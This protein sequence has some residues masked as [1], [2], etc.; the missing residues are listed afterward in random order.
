LYGQINCNNSFTGEFKD[1]TVVIGINTIRQATIKL[2]ER[3]E[4]REV[5]FQK[6]SIISNYKEYI[7]LQ[8][9]QIENLKFEN[10]QLMEQNDEYIRINEEIAESLNKQKRLTAFAGGIASVGIITT[11]ILI[12]VK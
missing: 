4:Y 7:S 11:L 10:Y 2:I 8:N 3:N 9:N 1:T 6:D 5:C 12:F